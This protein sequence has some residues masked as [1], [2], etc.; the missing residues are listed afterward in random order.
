LSTTTCAKCGGIVRLDR[1]TCP[2]CGAARVASTTVQTALAT[3]A[4]PRREDMAI[5]IRSRLMWGDKP[6]EIREELVKQ[7][8]RPT[9]LDGM[10][11]TAIQERMNFYRALGRKNIIVGAALLVVGAI[12]LLGAGSF[13]DGAGPR[14]LPIW[15]LLAG[16]VLPIAGILLA[17]KGVR[18]M[19]RPGE[20]ESTAHGKGH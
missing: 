3:V 16:I 7:G 15:A 17:A 20:G 14:Q 12:F 18:R 10:I 9:E 19:R 11:Q 1:S 6:T 2:A 8:A 13:F 4:L 5:H